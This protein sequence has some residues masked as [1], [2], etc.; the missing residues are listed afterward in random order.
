M[1][2][3]DFATN[4]REIALFVSN[5]RPLLFIRLVKSMHTKWG[6]QMARVHRYTRRRRLLGIKYVLDIT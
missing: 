6:R 4:V 5:C 2:P 3:S 1:K